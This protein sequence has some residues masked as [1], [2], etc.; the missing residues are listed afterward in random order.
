MNIDPEIESL[1]SP[2]TQ[3]E[4]TLLEQQL[5]LSNGPRDSLIVW[6]EEDILL[7]GHNRLKICQQYNLSYDLKSLSFPDR[8]QAMTWVINNQLGRRNATPEQVSY[9][10]GWRY[11]REKN[12]VSNPN[13][14]NQHVVKDNSYPQPTTAEKLAQEYNS[15]QMTI[16][17]DGKFAQSVDYLCELLSNP[18]FRTHSLSKDS[19]FTR[20]DI[21]HL[22]KNED[23]LDLIKLIESDKASSLKEA[24]KLL[25][26]KKHASEQPTDQEGII[27]Y[28][29]DF[30]NIQLTSIDA[31]ITDPPYPEEYLPLYED[32]GHWAYQSLKEGGSLLVMCGQSYLPQIYALLSKS[33]MTYR[34]TLAYLTP[35]GQAVQIWQSKVNTFWK[36]VLWFTKGEYKGD[37]N[38]DVFKSKPNDN[39]KRFHEWGQSESGM[40]ELVN[41][42]SLPGQTI[43]DPFMG[44]GT[45]G[46]VCKATGRNFTGIEIKEKTYT[47]ARNRINDTSA[48]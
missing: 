36:P 33:N 27:L 45:T 18:S 7:D 16:K 34:W 29:D 26:A 47:S 44:G 31:I 19:P 5:I 37:W 46:I 8:E 25:K 22:A 39:D 48:E 32:L 21:I 17:N 40:L 3:Q 1:I 41:S 24:K 9:Y 13:G 12:L 35:G 11:N 6:Q 43:C 2:L 20:K 15:S 4:Y 30:R 10:R 38:G 14:N 42:F 28:N 23:A